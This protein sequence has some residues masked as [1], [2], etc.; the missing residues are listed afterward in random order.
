MDIPERN[1]RQTLAH[2]DIIPTSH[3]RMTPH[4]P[5]LFILLPYLLLEPPFARTDR[6]DRVSNG[7]AGVFR[8]ED[9]L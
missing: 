4:K 5:H 9:M 6:G 8:I 1:V 2:I 3:V 7:D